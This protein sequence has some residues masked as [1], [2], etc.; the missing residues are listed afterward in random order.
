MI[1]D[2]KIAYW[3]HCLL[4]GGSERPF[5]MTG[6]KLEKILKTKCTKLQY[7]GSNFDEAK[8]AALHTAHLVCSAAL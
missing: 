4:I 6:K 7:V 5:G 1:G 3:S 8:C 2:L